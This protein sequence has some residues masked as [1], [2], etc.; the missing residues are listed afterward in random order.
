MVRL[1]ASILSK[2]KN[3]TG[4]NIQLVPIALHLT[5]DDSYRALSSAPKHVA[6]GQQTCFRQ[7]MHSLPQNPSPTQQLPQTMHLY[8]RNKVYQRG[9][10]L[11]RVKRDFLH[12]IF[13]LKGGEDLDKC[14]VLISFF[15][16]LC[17]KTHE[18]HIVLS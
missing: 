12:Y 8:L 7:G 10:T 13:Y 1:H 6:D 5:K 3:A 16:P 18:A 4:T 11:S 2:Q 14:L 9:L 15:V 17:N